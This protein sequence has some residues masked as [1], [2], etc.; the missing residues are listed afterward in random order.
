MRNGFIDDSYERLQAVCAALTR[1]DTLVL[2]TEG[3]AFACDSL[4]PSLTR[5]ELAGDDVPLEAGAFNLARLTRLHTLKVDCV[6]MGGEP[7]QLAHLHTT[8][9]SLTVMNSHIQESDDQEELFVPPS[10]VNLTFLR[11]GNQVDRVRGLERLPPKLQELEICV[12][13]KHGGVPTLDLAL[14]GVHT[15]PSLRSL[16]VRGMRLAG[17]V[18][19]AGQLIIDAS[20]TPDASCASLHHP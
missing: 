3:T 4:P 17:T 20:E 19:N 2:A 13:D 8:L 1:L 5:L 7:Y 15:A 12:H 14:I 9:R 10:F 18:S 6:A 11:L 16:T